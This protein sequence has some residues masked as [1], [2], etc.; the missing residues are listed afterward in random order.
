MSISE[1]NTRSAEPV[2]LKYLFSGAT[3]EGLPTRGFLKSD[4]KYLLKISFDGIESWTT[5][6]MRTK[7]ST[8]VW[9]AAEDRKEFEQ[10]STC[11]LQ[12][13]LYKNHSGRSQE[14]LGTAMLSLESWLTSSAT[15]VPATSIKYKTSIIIKLSIDRQDD[16]PLKTNVD[17]DVERAVQQ[18]AID[19]SGM[20]KL[21]SLDSAAVAAGQLQPI[22]NALTSDVVKGIESSWEPLLDKLDAFTK[23]MDAVVEVHPYA[24]MAWTVI[25]AAYKLVRGQQDRDAR[26]EQLVEKMQNVY[27]FLCDAHDLQSDKSREGV[28]SRLSMQTVE[29]GHSISTYARNATFFRRILEQSASNMNAKIHAYSSSF[30][31]LLQDFRT[32]SQLRTEITTVRILADIKDLA[33]AM[34]LRDIFYTRGAGY[35]IGKT[36]LPG[37]RAALLDDITAW[38]SSDV[39][40]TP[41]T[42]LLLGRAGTGKSTVAHTIAGRFDNLKQLGSMFCFRRTEAT[43]TPESL[44]RNI[45][46]DLCDGWPAFRDALTKS[47]DGKTS[48]CST[49]DL[50]LQ[51]SSF[52]LGPARLL[53]VSGTIVVI[54]DALDECGTIADR[55]KLLEILSHR[56]QQLP[57][58]FRFLITAR[59]EPDIE[60][61]FL[62]STISTI[63]KHMPTPEKDKQLQ[64]DILEYIRHTLSAPGGRLPFGLPEDAC[65]TLASK[66]EGLFQWAYVACEYLKVP[67]IGSTTQRRYKQL[68]AGK[69]S[70][71]DSLYETVL[72]PLLV[73]SPVLESFKCILGFVLTAVEPLPRQSLRDLVTLL[74]PEEFLDVDEILPYLGSLLS[75]VGHQDIGPVRPLHSSFTDLLQRSTSDNPYYIGVAGHHDRLAI[76]SLRLLKRDLRFNM[77]GLENSYR[78][79]TDVSSDRKKL[80]EQLTYACKYWGQHLAMS[81]EDFELEVADLLRVL[82][83]ENFLFWL[84]A[85]SIAGAVSEIP[86]CALAAIDR[87][88]HVDEKMVQVVREGVKFVR[89]F[90][91][92]IVD[93][94]AH[95]Y[96]SALVW[97]PT[98]STIAALYNSNF[99]WK[100]RISH[101]AAAAWPSLSLSIEDNNTEEITSVT[102]TPNGKRII[103]GS[104]DATIRVWD[105]ETGH[106]IGVPFG[107]RDGFSISLAIYPDGRRIVCGSANKTLQIW[108]TY[109]GGAIGEPLLGHR[110]SVTSVA[111]STDGQRI[112]SGS[113]DNTVRIWDA[114]TRRTVGRPLLGHHESVTSVAISSDGRHIVSGS[115]DKTVRIWNATT[116]HGPSIVISHQTWVCS[117]AISPD[118]D[119]IISGS[120]NGTLQFWETKTGHAADKPFVGHTS[121]V[122]STAI[123]SDGTRIASASGDG[124][125]RMWDAE[126]GL[127]IGQ[128][129]RS[130][131][132]WARSVAIS[133]DGRRVVSGYGDGAVRVWDMDAGYLGEPLVGH[134]PPVNS[135]VISSDGKYILSGCSDEV[136]RILDAETGDVLSD[137]F[138]GHDDQVTSVA[139]S[140]SGK[141]IV[142]GSLDHTVRLWDAEAETAIGEPLAG[143]ERT[144]SSVAISPDESWI[145][146][147]SYDGTV[148][149]WDSGTLKALDDPLIGHLSAVDSV[150][151]S[152]DGNR[153]VSGSSDKTVRLWD[154][155]TKRPIGEPLVGH[156]DTVLAVT[157][158]ADGKHIVSGSCDK[159]VRLW[160][161]TTG[162]PIGEPLVGHSKMVRSV[163]ILADRKRIVSGSEDR[164]IRVWDVETRRQVGEPLTGHEKAV[165]SVA[166]SPDQRWIAS[167]SKDGTIRLWDLE[168]GVPLRNLSL[169]PEPAEQPSQIYESDGDGQVSIKFDFA[170]GWIVANEKEYILWVPPDQMHRLYTGQCRLI[171]PVETMVTIDLSKFVHGKRWTECYKPLP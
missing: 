93:S 54:I 136:V 82:F 28:L 21:P 34:E 53:A 35:E 18:A 145:A 115:D 106:A 12:A 99:P 83:L 78:L 49:N 36:C 127:A 94:A 132:S 84:D 153:I 158:S 6:E 90:V 74:E 26:V 19:V 61:S 112:V 10:T 89:T 110:D 17:P 166:V 111:I 96:L 31:D 88:Q 141:L 163:S 20:H 122:W 105:A 137:A 69:D 79:N 40:D 151:I 170:S 118:G 57:S 92:P 121:R 58:T 128:P 103:C 4:G 47:I 113:T 133:A 126:M 147:G 167:A 77:G 160:D 30:D 159:T 114:E 16:V 157:I 138:E 148:Q 109:T 108:D 154:A 29:C 164:T 102:F 149:L 146:S 81:R 22:K 75:G 59:A 7:E 156:T 46:R 168:A 107:T 33:V 76:S 117:V 144:V 24:K 98:T 120:A 130:G 38:A 142:S 60:E 70:R 50:E 68:E 135:V 134:E 52:L 66:A 139:I 48:R 41:R 13:I 140:Q 55:Q 143:H 15:L 45:A 37:T 51:F 8:V 119:Y 87:L 85:A 43:R 91:R 63:V 161:A 104:R 5:R 129:L 3:V 2:M 125:V 100:A 123:S 39:V 64:S 56:V 155:K 150:A 65:G 42:Y 165:L 73:E 14:E 9:S 32:G 72:Q 131:N 124:T 97:T 44:F 1:Q 95:V 162:Q 169:S 62:G 152:P 27:D 171:I 23:M 116:G 80:P 101:C 67:R 25:S 11:N 71:L 86:G